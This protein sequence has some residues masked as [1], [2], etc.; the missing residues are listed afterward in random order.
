MLYNRKVIIADIDFWIPL[1]ED[2]QTNQL[3]SAVSNPFGT[4]WKDN[5]MSLSSSCFCFSTRYKVDYECSF[6]PCPIIRRIWFR[7]FYLNYPVLDF[8]APVVTKPIRAQSIRKFLK[9]LTSQWLYQ[10]AIG[11]VAV[12]AGHIPF[13]SRSI[14]HDYR[15]HF[16]FIWL[17]DS[18]ENFD[19]TLSYV[20]LTT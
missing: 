8:G 5:L 3:R 19:T 7:F 9:S 18:S 10:I 1:I 6:N 15:Y 2:H 13:A 11:M 17:L 4:A 16:Q 12:Y 14:Q 20:F